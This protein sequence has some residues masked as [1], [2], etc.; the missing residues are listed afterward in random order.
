MI[1]KD[2]TEELAKQETEERQRLQSEQQTLNNLIR[3]ERWREALV[4]TL[5]LEQPFNA[6]KV[7]TA[8]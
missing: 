5:K 4:L 1:W 2:V 3:E 8:Q 6:L 7:S